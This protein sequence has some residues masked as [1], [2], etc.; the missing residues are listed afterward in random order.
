MVIFK[1]LSRSSYN[2]HPERFQKSIQGILINISSLILARTAV[3]PS[4]VPHV[5]SDSP[6]SGL[7][8]ESFIVAA[9]LRGIQ[10]MIFAI[11]KHSPQGFKA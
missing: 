7:K 3:I 4:F 5:K 8:S 2:A 9:P 6:D 1:S 11:N 10:A